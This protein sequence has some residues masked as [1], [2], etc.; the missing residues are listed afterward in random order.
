MARAPTHER[1][2][3]I[4]TGLKQVFA[5]RGYAGASMRAIADAAGLTPGLLHY[6]FP[7]KRAML[8]GLIERLQADLLARLEPTGGGAAALGDLVDALLGLGSADPAAVACWSQA[9]AE[10]Q[11]DATVRAA[12]RAALDALLARIEPALGDR[13]AAVGLLAAIEGYLGLATTCPDLI[14]AGS[15]APTVRAMLAG[16]QA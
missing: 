2:A 16:L 10:A 5:D 4:L 1:R 3:Q 9:R 13:A 14:P 6:H 15:A 12:Y 8:V 7:N 11:R